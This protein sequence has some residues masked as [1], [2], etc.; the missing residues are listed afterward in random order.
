MSWRH[1]HAH[2]HACQLP[3]TRTA[4]AIL[5]RGESV[6]LLPS[7]FWG[8]LRETFN[9][10]YRSHA[11]CTAN[12]SKG[13]QMPYRHRHRSN[14]SPASQTRT[15]LDTLCSGQGAATHHMGGILRRTT[16]HDR[17]C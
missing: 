14:T 6:I 2:E 16:H 5:I 17:E 11:C 3:H 12:M 8:L 10:L 7:L 13:F 9:T 1:M 15:I 4:L